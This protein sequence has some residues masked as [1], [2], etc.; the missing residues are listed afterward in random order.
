MADPTTNQSILT[1]K[2]D[3]TTTTTTTTQRPTP[4]WKKRKVLLK[5]LSLNEIPRHVAWERRRRLK[6][7]QEKKEDTEGTND[8]LSED[9]NELKG[10]LQLG[11]GFNDDEGGQSL[12]NTLPALDIYFA[13]NRLGSPMVSPSSTASPMPK[14]E[15]VGSM[16][17]KSGETPQQVKAKLR[18]WAQAVACSMIS[19]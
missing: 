8:E 7:M 10:C 4:L 12:T 11:F 16:S 1:S 9:L 6:R 15:R 2:S 17:S 18:H 3:T 13:V 5:E 14:F 19:S